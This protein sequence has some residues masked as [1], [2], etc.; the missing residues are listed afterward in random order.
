M[1]DTCFLERCGKCLGHDKKIVIASLARIKEA[2]DKRQD[3]VKQRIFEIHGEEISETKVPVHKKCIST[4]VSSTHINRLL[5]KRKAEEENSA[6]SQ[7]KRSRSSAKIFDFKKH[8]LFCH[9]VK[10]CILP[11]EYD[12]K[13]NVERRI[14]AYNVRTVLMA[15]DDG[16]TYKDHILKFCD[17]RN[18]SLGS[19]VRDRVLSTISDLHADEAR[20]HLHCKANF[21][22]R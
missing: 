8:C 1:A 6:Q 10:E 3:D 13:V 17:L 12:V 9:D 18:D 14:P 11:A 19:I 2:S 15:Q 5:D 22:Q 16:K 21:F 7:T 4:Y 20:Y